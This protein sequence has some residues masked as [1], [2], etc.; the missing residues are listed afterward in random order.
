MK[1][2]VC[3]CCRMMSVIILVGLLQCSSSRNKLIDEN[4]NA[5]N[6]CLALDSI[7]FQITKKFDTASQVTN[8]HNNLP[9]KLS[10]SFILDK[11]YLVEYSVN[12]TM[13]SNKVINIDTNSS[14]MHIH[15]ISNVTSDGGEAS[16]SESF[17]ILTIKEIENLVK[18]NFDFSV[19][20]ISPSTTP[21]PYVDVY[22]DRKLDSLRK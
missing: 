17:K 5:V 6:S 18:S 22:F 9:K 15:E 21:V 3:L 19:F 10:I 20:G 13:M 11:N 2:I 8:L 1:T 4:S 16:F 12:I 7:A 14:T